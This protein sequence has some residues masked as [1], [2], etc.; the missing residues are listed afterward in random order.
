MKRRL[1]GD[2]IF[3]RGD[4]LKVL[5]TK[6]DNSIDLIITDPP[7][8][9]QGGGNKSA[10]RPRGMLNA[11]DGKIFKHNNLPASAYMP[12]LYRVLKPGS[13]CYVMINKD[14]L[15]ALITAAT[16]AGFGWH[17]ILFWRKNTCTPNRWYM[18]EVELVLLFYKRPIR[19]LNNP[20][21]KQVI[22]V[23][24]PR[25]KIH[26]TEKPAALFQH[27]I[28]NSSAPGDL[29][30]DPFAGSGALAHA[31]E[32]CGRRWIC[33]EKDKSFAKAAINRLR[34]AL[35]PCKQ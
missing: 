4:A 7:Y 11:N 6:H 13:H 32:S 12:E 17:N 23:D 16:S 8:R 22:E 29:V 21:S 28:E 20:G 2:G 31:A 24:N 30:L 3:Y 26:P 19:T 33:I 34:Q 27:Y 1:I 14:N 10:N 25:N 9:V 15:V 5:A 18:K 35:K